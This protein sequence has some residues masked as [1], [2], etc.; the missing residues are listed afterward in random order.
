MTARQIIA[1]NIKTA[2][3]YIK[4]NPE[5]TRNHHCGITMLEKAMAAK[6]CQVTPKQNR[7]DPRSYAAYR[8]YVARN[9]QDMTF[10]MYLSL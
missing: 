7:D 9:E 8:D 5:G 4:R 10:E 2:K 1:K 3:D 6:A